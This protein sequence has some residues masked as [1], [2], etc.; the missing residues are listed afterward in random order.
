MN[1]YEQLQEATQQW[2]TTKGEKADAVK[3]F[4]ESL[5]QLKD[6]ISRLSCEIELEKNGIT[7]GEIDVI[8]K[9]YDECD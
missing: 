5:K 2:I 8:K 3:I 4:N 1:R 7:G 6:E 9:G